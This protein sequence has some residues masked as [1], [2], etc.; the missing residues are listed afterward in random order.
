MLPK[1]REQGFNLSFLDVMA[2]GLGAVILILILVRFQDNTDIPSDE[3]ERLKQELAA[4]QDQKSELQQSLSVEQQNTSA[5]T[6][7]LD[8]IKQRIEALK[9]QQQG[10][11]SALKDQLAVIADLE[12]AIAAIA[13]ETANDP[14]QTPGTKEENYL[15]GLKVEGKRI[16]ILIDSSASMTEEALIDVISRKLGSDVEKQSGRKWQRTMRIANWLI[17]RLPNDAEFSVVSFSNKAKV[18]G[19]NRVNRA[20]SQSDLRSVLQSLQTVVPANGTNLLVGLKEINIAMPNM[21]DLYLVT[22][23]LPTILDKNAA[24]KSSRR[25]DPEEGK[26]PTITGACRVSVFA[27][28][29]RLNPLTSVKSNII[30]LPL[31]GDPEAPSA[32]WGWA[33][34]TSGT[35]LAPAGTWP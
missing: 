35:F 21:T 14:I 5:K 27:H 9:I 32:F 4:L 34:R 29:M 10:T 30:L 33:N 26:Q 19:K 25:C 12:N 31:E 20:S 7:T 18:H 6:A 2:C 17:A 1:R 3:I 15:L 22:D 23:G 28:S 8:E 13:P 16:G 11:T 24:F